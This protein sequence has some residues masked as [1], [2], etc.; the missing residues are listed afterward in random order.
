MAAM[1]ALSVRISPHDSFGW[2]LLNLVWLDICFIIAVTVHEFSHAFA[3]RLVGFRIF[4]VIV[5]SGRTWWRGALLGFDVE[6][7]AFPFSGLTFGAPRQLER[8]P[9]KH[10]FFIAAA[11]LANVALVGLA[12]LFIK[13]PISAPYTSDAFNGWFVLGLAN[14]IT[15]FL[16][17][18]PRT[19]QKEIGTKRSDGLF[20]L[21]L[22]SSKKRSEILE[23]THV[24]W[25]CMEAGACI[26]Q[27]RFAEGRG[28]LD[29]G[30]A[31]FPKNIRLRESYVATLIAI[32]EYQAARST[33]VELLAEIPPQ[34]VRR[35]MVLNNI[36][37]LDALL[38]DPA[39]FDEADRYSTE[40][41]AAIPWHPA[42]KNT[43]GVV[44]LALNRLD[45]ALP[46]LRASANAPNQPPGSRA[47]C[48][49]TLA[50][51][52][53]RQ[54]E[55]AAAERYFTTARQINPQCP[56]LPRTETVL[57]DMKSRKREARG[58][59]EVSPG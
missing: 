6:A 4:R 43:R 25:F 23:E 33:A 56:L 55:L 59:A 12:A 20:L 27:G 3:G 39:L 15:V 38:E 11:P 53:A 40:A 9:W 52:E 54:D 5:G 36:A 31:E 17:L 24:G 49:C 57:A 26:E 34:H 29:R 37:Y 46:L 58:A 10:L 32:G 41:L 50:M 42:L 30:L 35:L 16:S 28:W 44:L 14:F 7:K 51:A 8:T 1:G 18:W 21:Q 47:E 22:L 45:E 2:L 48:L 13:D 19:Y